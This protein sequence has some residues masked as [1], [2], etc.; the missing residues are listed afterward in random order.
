MA[1]CIITVF[2]LLGFGKEMDDT[3][4]SR[5]H[6]TFEGIRQVDEQGN[7]Y[8]LAR[9]LSL[10]LEY[11]QY[12]HFLAVIERAKIACKKSGR[13]LEDHFEDLLTM[14]DIG[15]GA[16]RK[17]SDIRLSR[18]ACYLIVQNGD[19]SKTVIANG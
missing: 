11:S 8:W 9:K 15:T 17:I 2:T 10:V 19:P 12:R 6:Q 16:K 4:I 1:A 18:Y 3:L 13:L 14:V 5:H 7:E